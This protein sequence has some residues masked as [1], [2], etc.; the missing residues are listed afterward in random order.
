MRN[1]ATQKKHWDT[2]VIIYA[3]LL[4]LSEVF[5]YFLLNMHNMKLLILLKFYLN[6]YPIQL[7][8]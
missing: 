3:K 5:R 1:F 6:K 4:F 7:R 2:I 8:A